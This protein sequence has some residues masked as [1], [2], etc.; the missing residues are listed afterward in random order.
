VEPTAVNLWSLPAAAINDQVRGLSRS[1]HDDS[2]DVKVLVGAL[3]WRAPVASGRV[4]DAAGRGQGWSPAV[5][6]GSRRAIR[7]SKERSL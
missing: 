6:G 4:E 7:Y 1:S 5:M 3:F 2:Q